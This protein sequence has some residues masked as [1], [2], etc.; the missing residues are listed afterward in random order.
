MSKQKLGLSMLKAAVSTS[1]WLL[2]HFGSHRAFALP[3]T[4]PVQKKAKTLRHHHRE[5]T[6]FLTEIRLEDQIIFNKRHLKEAQCSQSTA[7]SLSRCAKPVRSDRDV[8][9]A[10]MA[11]LDQHPGPGKG[12]LSPFPQSLRQLLCPPHR[13]KD[14]L[15]E[16]QRRGRV[17]LT[18]DSNGE[19][20]DAALVFLVQLCQS[21]APGSCAASPQ[22]T[23]EHK[24]HFSY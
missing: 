13:E 23:A 21:Q 22:V 10:L 5:I 2:L 6:L 11:G 3:R 15:T 18:M 14:L 17:S 8:R 4:F 16:K 24:L 7:S 12:E 20:E 19:V 9:A 1:P